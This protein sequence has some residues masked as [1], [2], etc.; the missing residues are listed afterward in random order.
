M[1]VIYTTDDDLVNSHLKALHSPCPIIHVCMRLDLDGDKSTKR[2]ES[3]NLLCCAVKARN[4]LLLC[5]MAGEWQNTSIGCFRFGNTYSSEFMLIYLHCSGLFGFAL[6]ANLI[7]S[8]H[9]AIDC[10]FSFV[11]DHV[12][13]M[14]VFFQ[15]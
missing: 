6:F 15:Q 7:P 2:T 13:H 8:F 14:R 9:S 12:T 1:Y 3:S 4:W 10:G 11:M 5:A